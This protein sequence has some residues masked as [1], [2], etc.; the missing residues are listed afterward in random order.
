MNDFETGRQEYLKFGA[1]EL[2]NRNELTPRNFFDSA[3][4]FWQFY[5][6]NKLGKPLEEVVLAMM[7]TGNLLSHRAFLH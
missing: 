1:G 4:L 7:R 3:M 6:V 5:V 2:K